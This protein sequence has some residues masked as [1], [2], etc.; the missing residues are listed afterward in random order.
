MRFY[1]Y[2]QWFSLRGYRT[3]VIALSGLLTATLSFAHDL[4][5]L[6]SETQAGR[7][8]ASA[9][10]PEQDKLPLK[11]LLAANGDSKSFADSVRGFANQ[12]AEDWLKDSIFSHF[13]RTEVSL[14][15]G[16]GKPVFDILTVQPFYESA[17]LADSAFFQGSIFGYD[18]R[19]T[20]NLGLGYRRMLFDEKLLAGANA[21]FDHEF[22]NGHRRS[23]LGLELRSS[24]AEINLNRY[25]A[26]TG[27]RND[28]D[29]G[30]ARSLPGHDVELGVTL[31][32]LP[33]VK[34]YAKTFRWDAYDGAPDVKGATYS[35]SGYLLPGLQIEAG[36]TNYTTAGNAD[37]NFLRLT[38]TLYLEKTKDARFAKPFVAA[39]PY[40]LDS[41]KEM[42]FDKVR[43]E[44]RIFK[45]KRFQV[46][47]SGF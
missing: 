18:G 19:T 27:W 6:S 9:A 2:L 44:N 26:V 36:R 13:D 8:T 46:S 24:V 4:P 39:V 45:Q 33:Y 34:V 12:K 31:P 21:F 40:S 32:Y 35:L 29:G 20:L 30:Q 37:E 28:R 15:V 42:R 41:M 23:S 14:Q 7:A 16:K 22:P 43:R 5:Q 3:A 10:A 47:A 17:D 38:Y 1:F 25:F 11:W